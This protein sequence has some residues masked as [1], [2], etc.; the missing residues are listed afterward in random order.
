MTHRFVLAALLMVPALA[1]AEF[2]AQITGYAAAPFS[3]NPRTVEG[4]AREYRETRPSDLLGGVELE[5]FGRNLGFGARYSGRFVNVTIEDPTIAESV[6]GTDNW[7][8]DWSSDAYVAYHLFGA[9]SF[10]DPY[11]RYGLGIAMRM[12]LE[13]D[14]Y[15]DADSGDWVAY[16]GGDDER[17]EQIN[18]AGFYQYLGAG[19]QVNLGGLVVGA[20]INYNIVTQSAGPEWAEFPMQRFEAR[21]YGGVSFGG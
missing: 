20:G 11:V 10:L 16:D 17:Y 12:D 19:A 7:W 13:R 2:G 21:L 4:A 3:D 1:W 6:G 5:F 15:L 18:S 8:Y 9:G 14:A